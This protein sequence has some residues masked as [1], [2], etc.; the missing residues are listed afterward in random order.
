MNKKNLVT[1]GTVLCLCICIGA[2]TIIGALKEKANNNEIETK[3]L[4]GTVMQYSN[5]T[6]TIK[7]DDANVYTCKAQDTVFNIGDNISI[8]YTGIV[9][10]NYNIQDCQVINY[11]VLAQSTDES[12][13]PTS[14]L[15]NGIFSAFYKQ[16][17]A[18]LKT[19]TLGEKIGQVLLA[20]YPDTNQLD[21]IKKY[22]FGGLVFFERD[23]KDKSELEVKKMIENAQG[24]SK[25]PLL[26]AVDEEGG[27]V[28]RVSSNLLLVQ[29]K[30]KSSSELYDLGGF[31]KIEEDTKNKSRILS[32]LGLNLNLAPVVDVANKSTDY[33]YDRTLKQN[34]SLTSTFAKTVISA[35]KGTGV[36]YT[37]KHFPGYGGN[38]DTHVGGAVDTRSRDDIMTNDIPPFRAGIEA[39]AEAVL[40]SHNVVS[41]IDSNNPASLSASVHEILKKDLSFTGVTITDDL[42]MGALNDIDN[43]TIKAVKAGNDLII[44]TDYKT[45]FDEI[46][47]AISDGT[48]TSEQI[49]KMAFKVLAWKYYKMMMNV[50]EK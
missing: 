39:G 41:N 37:L 46:K 25:I 12:G 34:T 49:D 9:D 3:E 1:V 19:M 17:F 35:S 40:I 26:T 48:L 8:E 27:K 7:D 43:T 47:N 13:I 30:F 29:E 2:I 36:S 45:S 11:E 33:M 24:T 15:D 6:V 14:W 50:N 32:N 44:T 5:G 4:I 31:P 18:K 10:K 23:F 16:A 22:G 42:D 28:V 20:R 38:A 21:D